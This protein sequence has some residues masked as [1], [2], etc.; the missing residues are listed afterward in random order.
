LTQQCSLPVAAPRRNK[1][2]RN[3]KSLPSA[4]PERTRNMKEP[5]SQR[6]TDLSQLDPLRKSASKLSLDDL[7][8]E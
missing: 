7:D 6:V 1:G 2:F 5:I 8:N 3:G 4:V